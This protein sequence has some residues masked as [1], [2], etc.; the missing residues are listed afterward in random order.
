MEMCKIMRNG[1]ILILIIVLGFLLVSHVSAEGFELF[2][3]DQS[4]ASGTLATIPVIIKNAEELAEVSF[5]ISY[6]PAILKFSGAD[7]GDISKN[8]I[9]EVSETKPGTIFINFVEDS[10]ISQ[11]GEI[12]KLTF[13]VPGSIG[14][15]AMIN[16][17]P[18]KIQNLDK[19]DVPFNVRS[20]TIK[21]TGSGQ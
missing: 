11:D 14:S 12:M 20:G 2:I 19:N 15:S 9:F 21:V 1:K 7:S 18:K 4:V 10:G 3:N 17:I 16:I 13:E 8:G 6:D 5:E